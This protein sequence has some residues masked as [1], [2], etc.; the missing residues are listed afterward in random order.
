LPGRSKKVSKFGDPTMQLRE[1]F[2]QIGHAVYSMG[3]RTRL[4][5]HERAG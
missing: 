4:G 3:K 2:H 5:V 1:I